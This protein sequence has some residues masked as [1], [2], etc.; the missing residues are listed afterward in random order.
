MADD[1]EG[2]QGLECPICSQS[3]RRPICQCLMGHS[4][5]GACFDENARRNERCP[6]CRVAVRVGTG[7]RNY[8]L[9]KVADVLVLR[10]HV[11]PPPPRPCRVAPPPSPAVPTP[12]TARAKSIFVDATFLFRLVALSERSLWA[13]PTWPLG[14]VVTSRKA[15]L[16]FEVPHLI[17]RGD[18]VLLPVRLL[19]ERS[20]AASARPPWRLQAKLCHPDGGFSVMSLPVE[21][22][23]M[24]TFSFGRDQVSR[25]AYVRDGGYVLAFGIHVEPA[26][27]GRA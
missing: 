22:G 2:Q 27:A 1:D 4:F 23:G 11:T 21:A 8:A 25:L 18:E 3:M 19:G 13:Q 20:A 9:E 5:C 26:S 7:I 15:A 16:T 17:V 6:L 24:S 14:Y 10:G 12:R